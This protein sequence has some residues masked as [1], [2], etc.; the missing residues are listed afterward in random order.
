MHFDEVLTPAH[1]RVERATCLSGGLRFKIDEALGARFCSFNHKDSG[2][3][4]GSYSLALSRTF[5]DLCV[6]AVPLHAA[7]RHPS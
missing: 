5:G 4:I 1:R 6:G 7:P 3:A 2:F